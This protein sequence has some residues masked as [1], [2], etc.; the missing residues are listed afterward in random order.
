MKRRPDGSS[1][2]AT[3]RVGRR[4]RLAVF[5]HPRLA[6]PGRGSRPSRHPRDDASDGRG[7][8]PAP[9][10]GN[11]RSSII[12]LIPTALSASFL[13]E[14]FVEVACAGCGRTQRVRA[15]KVIPC[16]GYTSS[17]G[18]CKQNPDFKP[19]EVPDGWICVRESHAAGGFSGW[20]IRPATQEEKRSIER[21]KAI[22]DA[23]LI[24]R[25]Q[26]N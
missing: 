22:R 7:L 1:R 16:N 25:L 15:S 4:E 20:T 2:F 11:R 10:L 13:N 5:P 26:A 9:A 6:C 23:G 21:A 3:Y 12:P 18:R 8:R 19:P 17:W 24:K 14:T